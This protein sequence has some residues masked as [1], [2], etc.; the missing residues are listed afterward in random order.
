[1][2]LSTPCLTCSQ[3]SSL[4]IRK[5]LLCLFFVNSVNWSS[6]HCA[7]LF[8]RIEIGGN[9]REKKASF[10]K[11]PFWNSAVYSSLAKLLQGQL[12]TGGTYLVL[13]PHVMLPSMCWPITWQ[14][15]LDWHLVC[16][17]QAPWGW[18]IWAHTLPLFHSCFLRHCF[19]FKLLA[20]R[21]H[22]FKIPAA[23]IL[24]FFNVVYTF[25]IVGLE[26]FIFL[27]SFHIAFFQ[28]KMFWSS[29]LKKKWNAIVQL[30]GLNKE[31]EMQVAPFTTAFFPGP[32]SQAL[33]PQEVS[34]ASAA[35]FRCCCDLLGISPYSF[36][37]NFKTAF[38]TISFADFSL[39]LLTRNLNLL[40]W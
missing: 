12:G 30:I 15:F 1:M 10:W 40:F 18:G 35:Q 32:L 38:M 36:H 28:K 26:L 8:P 22:L 6:I 29:P 5:T 9:R 2:L 20:L 31:A 3:K 7:I 39:G 14:P 27:V 34:S 16:E 25:P 19:L 17:R 23:I 37:S 11:R 24:F 21:F 33:S 4:V 13:L